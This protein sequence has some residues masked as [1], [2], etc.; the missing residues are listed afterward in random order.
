MRR[1]VAWA[2]VGATVILAAVVCSARMQSPETSAQP[3]WEYRIVS[4]AQL[5]GLESLKDA[6]DKVR[7][8]QELDAL[9]NDV[10]HRMTDLG[11][12]GWELV[13]LQSDHN[14]VFKRKMP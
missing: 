4:Y 6:L 3:R 8:V 9:N 7:T 11:K 13:C 14:F 1:K 5:S 12:Q 10:G 2:A